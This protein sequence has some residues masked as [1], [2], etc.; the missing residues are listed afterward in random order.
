MSSPATPPQESREELL[1][2]PR[3][4]CEATAIDR[5]GAVAG[6]LSRHSVAVRYGSLQFVAVRHGSLQFVTVRCGSVRLKRGSR[7]AFNSLL[8][9]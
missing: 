9:Q 7:K 4:P 8:Q 3:F 1:T 5:K 6:V 2:H